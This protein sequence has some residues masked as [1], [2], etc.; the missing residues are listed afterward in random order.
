VMFGSRA[1]FGGSAHLMVQLPNVKNSKW[2]LTLD[3]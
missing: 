2:W 1:G 3:S